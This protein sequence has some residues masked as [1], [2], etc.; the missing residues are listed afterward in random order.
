LL[1]ILNDIEVISYIETGIIR[2]KVEIVNF[3]SNLQSLLNQFKLKSLINENILQIS[4]HLKDEDANILTDGTRLAQDQQDRIFESFYQVDNDLTRRYGGTG[5]GLSLC[6]AYVELPGGKIWVDSE[7][8]K[9]STFFFTLPYLASD[10][11]V[12]P[13]TGSITIKR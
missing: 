5:L 8:G 1:S 6:R 4:L 13:Q 3:N 9:G 10:I 7:S 12:E 2:G 11:A